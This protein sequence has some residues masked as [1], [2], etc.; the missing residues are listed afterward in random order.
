MTSAPK[1]ERITAALGPAMKLARSTTF[2]PEK[3]LSLTIVCLLN[4]WAGGSSSPAVKLWCA[5]F[6]EGGGAFLLVLGCGAQAEIRSLEQQALALARLQALV[7]GLERELHRDRGVGGDLPQDRLGARNQF[8]G[9]HDLVDEPDPIGFLRADHLA[10]ENE[11]QGAALSHQ[12][13][14][15]LRAAAA[16]KQTELDFRLA[17]LRGLDCDPDS[18]GH[19]GLAAAAERKAID[20]RDHRLAEVLDEI[21]H[22]LSEA[23]RPFGVDRAGLRQLTDVGTG[24]ER[25][26]AG[27]R[28]D[29]AAHRRVV[30]RIL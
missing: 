2:N 8:G 15:A 4:Y 18:A 29:D 10:G 19:G 21:E 11:L 23:A 24:N 22:L 17:E 13:R 6:N 16:R 25:F 9:R 5:L 20:R 12:P 7:C 28:Q 14:Q 26:V 30:L 1:S 27:T 3:I